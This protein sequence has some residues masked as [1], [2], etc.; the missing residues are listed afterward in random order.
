MA[1]MYPSPEP[2]RPSGFRRR[3]LLPAAARWI[4]RK[5]R[6]FHIP[7]QRSPRRGTWRVASGT[8]EPI[9]P[10]ENGRGHPGNRGRGR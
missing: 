9:T 5:E 10:A 1:G 7:P 6:D 4:Q 8:R 2:P 3:S